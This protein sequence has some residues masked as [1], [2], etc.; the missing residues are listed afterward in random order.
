VVARYAYNV[1]MFLGN[2]EKF[3]TCLVVE[4]PSLSIISVVSRL[5]REHVNK[6]MY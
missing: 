3:T 2:A 4:I 1:V 6:Q 5:L